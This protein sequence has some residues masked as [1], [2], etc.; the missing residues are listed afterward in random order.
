MTFLGEKNEI[1]GGD[2]TTLDLNNDGRDDILI[3]NPDN[4]AA[5]SAAGKVQAI[6]SPF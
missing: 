2:L 5:G 1:G 4:A 3:G 6:Y